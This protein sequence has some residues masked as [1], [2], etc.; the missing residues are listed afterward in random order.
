MTKIRHNAGSMMLLLLLG[1]VAVMVTHPGTV[2][3]QQ[4]IPESGIIPGTNCS[5]I[6]GN[7]H[8]DCIP[9]YLSY[10]IKLAFSIAGGFA[11]FNIIQG[12][13]EYG[14]S[15]LPAGIVDKEAAKKRIYHAIIGFV[16][17][18]FTYLIIDTIVSV[19]F[20]G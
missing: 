10:L 9:L 3:A 6:T 7:F 14:I 11:L 16:V 18:I 19:L 12:G 15:G 8:F 2:F 13:Y 5:F 4:L 1:L 17:V 20:V